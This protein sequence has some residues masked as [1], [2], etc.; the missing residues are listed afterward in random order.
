M[1]VEAEIIR[2]LL[3]RTEYTAPDARVAALAA[4]SLEAAVDDIL[5]VTG[6]VAIPAS[7]Y[8]S[9]SGWEQYVAATKWWF[10]RMAFDSPRPIQEKMTFFWH[11]HFTSEW[12]KVN[13]TK[14]M[15]DQNALFRDNAFGDFRAL[16]QAMAIQPAM[17]RYLDNESNTKGSPNQNFA[18]ELMELYLL[19]VGNYT[20]GD[21]E[22][23]AKAWTGHTIKEVSGVEVYFYN[24]AIHDKT[25]KT[26]FGHAGNWSG[27]DIINIILADKG[28]ITARYIVGKLW[29]YFATPVGPQPTK[30]DEIA[31][32]FAS[33]W[34]IKPVVKAILM[35]DDFYTPATT[36]GL[37][38]TPVDWVVAV[39]KQSGYRAD[40]LNPQW[41]ME[42]MG[43]VPYNPPNVS[44]WRPNAAWVNTSSMGSRADFA[45][46]VVN[47]LRNDPRWAS[48]N[49]TWDQRLIKN[50]KVPVA[51]DDA[52]NYVAGLFAIAPLSEPTLNGMR[53][54]LNAER[55]AVDNPATDEWE[56]RNTWWEVTNLLQMAL[57][58]PEMHIA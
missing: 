36:Q 58:A 56:G 42:A 41:F 46:N 28:A 37:V 40:V 44:G 48:P 9:D 35:L 55:A 38:R 19:G 1:A 29:N 11:G 47:H 52:I 49:P 25:I 31:A 8:A 17:L 16:A 10:D 50:N 32:A 43:Q 7:I 2:H 21:V 12:N 24:D 14:M 33:N 15:M 51:V 30:L 57:V 23:S 27:A 3:R 20:E 6:P 18:R 53:T 39:M 54:Y 34:Q 13:D 45:G 4:G 22:A 5:N 26:F